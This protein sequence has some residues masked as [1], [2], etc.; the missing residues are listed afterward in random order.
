[1]ERRRKQIQ[2]SPVP[3]TEDTVSTDCQWC[4]E[5]GKVTYTDCGEV[6]SGTNVQRE[7]GWLWCPWCGKPIVTLPK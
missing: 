1:M 6:V 3:S 4:D 2:C 7:Y 5:N